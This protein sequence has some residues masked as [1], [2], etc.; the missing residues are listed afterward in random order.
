MTTPSLTLRAIRATPVEV[1]MARPLGT[2]AQIM[3][4]APLLLIDLETAEGIAGHA[5][6]FCYMRMAPG[7][8]AAVLADIQEALLGER[9]APV[10]FSTRLSRRYRLLG[11]QGIVRMALAGFDVACWD[12]LSLAAGLPLASYVGSRPRPIPAY[13]SNGL[14]L[15][16]P[17][18]AADEAEAL[19]EQGFRAVK[20]RLGRPTAEQDLAVV[21]AVRRRLPDSVALMADYNQALTV[22]EAIRRG[23]ALD[24]EGLYWIEEPTRHDD[25]A[26][27]ARIAAAL[28]TPVQIGEN[29]AGAPAMAAAL[30]ADACDYVMPDLERIGGV[31]GWQRAAALASAA[32]IE[33]SSHIFPE[34]SAHLLAATPTCHWLEYVDWAAPILAEPLRIA[35]GLAQV[36]D[37]PGSGVSWDQDA[38]KR[39]RIA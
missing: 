30:A 31:T 22:T 3:R 20:L 23:Q 11:A 5:Y 9:L 17:E 36:P 8:I 12:A 29:F 35:D 13:N 32:G 33:M 15:M 18:A 39:Y 6:L 7:L 21:R 27:H 2:S 16:P 10:D 19:L 1:P 38:V 25:Y 34:A 26:G 37:R 28:K 14:G 4:T 24:G